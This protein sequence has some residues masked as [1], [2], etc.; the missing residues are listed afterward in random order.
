MEFIHFQNSFPVLADLFIIVLFSFTNF[1][2]NTEDNGGEYL[3]H[4][5]WVYQTINI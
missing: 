5:K 1:I 4:L 3:K 2:Y